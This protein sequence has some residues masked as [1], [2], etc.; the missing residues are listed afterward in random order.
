MNK[1]FIYSYPHERSHSVPLYYTISPHGGTTEQKYVFQVFHVKHI[2][3]VSYSNICYLINVNE[4]IN[5]LINS[6]SV[7][8][9]FFVSRANERVYTVILLI[10]GSDISQINIPLTWKVET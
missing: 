4:N 3:V 6:S 10:Y 8:S 2:N 1:V 5:N 9:F 7:G